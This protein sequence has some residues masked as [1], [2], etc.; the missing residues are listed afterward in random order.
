M[1]LAS[2]LPGSPPILLLQ[3]S[4]TEPRLI[5][6]ITICKKYSQPW[7]ILLTGS[8]LRN[9]PG[10]RPN[11]VHQPLNDLDASTNYTVSAQVSGPAVSAANYCSAWIHVGANV[12]TGLIDRVDLSY[13]DFGKWL[14]LEGQFQPKSDSV[15]LY[16]RAACT[17]SGASHTSVLFWD[18]I[19]VAPAPVLD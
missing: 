9:A 1:R 4:P 19:I 10:N 11:W 14:T 13:D 3:P 7:N 2:S 6:E 16:L 8:A 18:D 5:Q 12:T 15:E 17:L